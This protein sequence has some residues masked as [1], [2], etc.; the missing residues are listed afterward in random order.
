[1]ITV[2]DV[3]TD[4]RARGFEADTDAQQ[5]AFINSIQRR[6]AGSH[7]W[8]WTIESQ[9]VVVVA[10]TPDY[11]L[12][13]APA[14]GH[15]ISIRQT[16]QGTQQPLGWMEPEALLERRALYV[17]SSPPMCWALTGPVTLSL[18]PTPAGAGALTL[19]YHKTPPTLTADADIP[20]IPL[21]YRD[22]LSVGACMLMA[23]RERQAVAAADFRAEYDER[24]RDM[25]AQYGVVQQQTP[26]IVGSSG[27]YGYD[28]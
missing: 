5:L 9:A 28:D 2:A 17:G 25:R 19:R 26:R 8:R 16:V 27:F 7:R 12:P 6:I 15:M 10:G 20:L 23:Q 24:M 1:M 13:S 14:G 18:W 3:R 4:I 21:G 22:L 11:T